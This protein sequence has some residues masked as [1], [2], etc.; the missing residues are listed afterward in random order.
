MAFP[1]FP[2]VADDIGA[3]A[4]DIGATPA[5]VGFAWLL[6]H[7]QNTLLIPGTRSIGHLEQNVAAGDITLTPDAV[8]RLDAVGSREPWA[9]GL[10]QF[11]TD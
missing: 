6:A 2:N 5:Q 7:S 10:D 8:A 3:V 4:D 11:V 9:L 1:G